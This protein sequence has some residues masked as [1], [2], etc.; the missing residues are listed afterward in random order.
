VKEKLGVSRSVVIQGAEDS[1]AELRGRPD[2]EIELGKQK[3][4]LEKQ[5][6]LRRGQSAS[7]VLASASLSE[8]FDNS[9]MKL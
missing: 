9:R 1:E 3:E 5:A 2:L 8:R 7:N 4:L 6:S